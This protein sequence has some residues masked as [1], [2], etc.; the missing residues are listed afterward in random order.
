MGGKRTLVF[1]LITQLSQLVLPKHDAIAAKHFDL[2]L[3]VVKELDFSPFT[4]KR[5]LHHDG[6]FAHGSQHVMGPARL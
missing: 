4:W 3:A 5:H 2:R 6:S 1:H